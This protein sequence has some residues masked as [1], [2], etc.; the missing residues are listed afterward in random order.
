VVSGR[1]GVGAAAIVI[2]GSGT[3]NP[4]R[5]RS[6]GLTRRKTVVESGSTWS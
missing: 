4:K 3:V 6:D 1:E 2:L 5:L